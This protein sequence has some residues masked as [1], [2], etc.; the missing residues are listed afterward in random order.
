M[1]FLDLQEYIEALKKKGELKIVGAK[2]DPVYEMGHIADRLIKSGGPAV[3]FK[4]PKGS[5]I[6]VAMNLFG[7]KSRMEFALGVK[8]LNDLGKRVEDLINVEAPMNF[9]DKLKNIMK[10]KEF[11]NFLPKIVENPPSQAVIDDDVDLNSLP[12]LKTWPEDGGKFIT[13]P[14][15]FT[16]NPISGKQNCGM[17]RMQIFDKNTTGMH[18]HIHK[19]GAHHYR[20]YKERG[21]KMPV[22][23]AIGA[24]PVSI[25]TATA[26]LPEDINEMMFAG[27]LRKKAVRLSKA[28]LSDILVPADAEIILEGYVDTKEDLRLEGP[29]G[30]HTGYYSLADYYPAFHVERITRKKHPIYPAT[31]VGKPP[32]EDCYIG[33][34]TERLFLP[35]IKKILPE[36]IDINMP[37]EGIFHNF[38]FVSIDKQFPGHA[39]KVMNALWGLGMMSLTKIIIVFDKDVNIQDIKDVI[40]RLGDNIDPKRDT[41]FTKGPLDILEHAS[42]LPNFGSKMGIDATKK[43]KGENFN[44]Q[45]PH[46]VVMDSSIVELV[47]KNWDRYFR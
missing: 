43:W 6:P 26:P 32:M 29:F 38:V 2:V 16:K 8:D 37:I 3:L 19:D 36:I 35:I 21:E 30:D 5:T 23:V 1:N 4:N 33:K 9:W 31:I 15:V 28:T 20:Y 46:D 40:W 27:F 12:V 11:A 47:D 25:Y 18:W 17:Y 41:L 39:Y 13:L 44:R 10:L 45:W 42:D 7:T 14:M 22:C 34:A 24:D